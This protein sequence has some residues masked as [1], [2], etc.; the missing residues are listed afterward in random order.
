MTSANNLVS[1]DT[2]DD[3]L[4]AVR[5]KGVRL[6]SEN[7]QLHYKAP[8]GALTQEEIAR[9]RVSK[10][11]IILHLER[12]A[13]AQIAEPRA[14]PRRWLDHIPLTF[15]QLAHWNLYRLNERPAIRQVASATRLRGW[16]NVDALQK[17]VAEVVRRHD[18]LRTRIVVMNGTP[19]QVISESSD[20]ELRVDDLT[21]LSGTRC[22]VEIERRIEQFILESVDVAIDP[23]FAALL[24]RLRDDEQ[25]LVVAMEHMISDMYSLNILLRDLF[26]VYMQA[27]K[28]RAFSLPEIPV[29]FPDYAVWQRNSQRLWI[30]KQGAYW[31]QRLTGCKRLRFP[32]DKDLPT[33]TR[34]GWGTVPIQI[35]SDL[36][37]ELREWCRL[38]RTTLVMSVF[39]AYVGLVLRWC[40]A[41]EAVFKYQSDGRFSPR[42]ENTIGSF[43]AA[44]YLRIRLLEDDS[45]VDLMNR[46]AEEYCRAY[47]HAD[48]SYMA[49]QVPRPE[50]TGNPAF[51]WVPQV[52]KIDLSGLDGSENTIKC[53]PV[54]FAH[55]MLKKLDMDNEPTIVLH[56]TDNEV[57]GGVHFPLNR[58]SVNTMERFA[59]NFLVFVG[60]LLRQPNGRVKET[61]LL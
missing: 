43:A 16:L 48:F 45:F 9:L 25:V 58:F 12:A 26:T 13:A 47:E 51:N 37:A 2:I 59:R 61:V 60:A 14:E 33:A 31:D 11:Q 38:K 55:P 49:A 29:Q 30:E 50:F 23:L 24:L 17:S 7:G 44:L 39:T 21:A 19:T 6:W 32:V 56:D 54:H 3:V 10:D 57:I 41:S 20:H 52:S 22:E 4:G 35:G 53:F 46:A 42:I 34:V 1:T 18:A 8:K 36:K 15:S 5:E 40:D 28:G 27:L